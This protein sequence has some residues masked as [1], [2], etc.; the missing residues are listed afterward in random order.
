[1]DCSAKHIASS[2]PIASIQWSSWPGRLT[3]QGLFNTSNP[4]HSLYQIRQNQYSLC[5]RGHTFQLLTINTTLFKINFHQQVPLSI[6]VIPL[7]CVSSLLGWCDAA[8][9]LSCALCTLS[10]RLSVRCVLWKR[11]KILL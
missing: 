5:K 11:L 8:S 3:L 4:N 9:V 7:G 2:S 10:V 6:C 1:M